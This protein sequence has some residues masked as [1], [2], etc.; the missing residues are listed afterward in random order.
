DRLEGGVGLDTMDGGQG[1]DVLLG[2]KGA[3]SL[4][5]GI[6]KDTVTGGPGADRFAPGDTSGTPPA[7][8]DGADFNPAV[9]VKVK[10][11]DLET[12]FKLTFLKGVR[13][14]EI[15]GALS[16]E[17]ESTGFQHTATG[18]DTV[19]YSKYSNPPTYG[20]HHPFDPGVT[21]V[22]TGV[23]TDEQAD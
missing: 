6:G 18:T 4:M 17:S 16:I 13:T 8:K 10:D 2:G 22:P 1:T 7:D 15:P 3:D 5:G 12:S 21:P 20:P 14:F 9:E 23:Y 11:D 19:D